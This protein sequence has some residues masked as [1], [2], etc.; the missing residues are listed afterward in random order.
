[1]ALDAPALAN[2]NHPH[3]M[4]A[5]TGSIARKPRPNAAKLRPTAAHVKSSA[6]TSHGASAPG[7]KSPGT[8][9]RSS[10]KVKTTAGGGGP[11]ASNAK[12]GTKP[13]PG[14]ARAK[15]SASNGTKPSTTG[16]KQH[17]AN[18]N[19]SAAQAHPTSKPGGTVKPPQAGVARSKP[20]G[21][22]IQTV[23]AQLGKTAVWSHS[24]N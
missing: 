20:N 23:S 17:A 21:T 4:D 19:S 14:A 11:N 2:K 13:R 18:V 5:I 15:P 1:M 22:P 16:V 9:S 24:L 6:T 10:A 8:T 3:P 12:P 7:P